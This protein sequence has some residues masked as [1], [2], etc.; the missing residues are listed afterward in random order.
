MLAM[1]YGIYR[2]WT[3]LIPAWVD[4]HF[5]CSSQTP[6]HTFFSSFLEFQSFLSSVHS[7]HVFLFLKKKRRKDDPCSISKQRFNTLNTTQL[8][9]WYYWDGV[10]GHRRRWREDRYT[11]SGETHS[12]QQG[13]QRKRVNLSVLFCCCCHGSEGLL[14]S[15]KSMCMQWIRVHMKE[16]PW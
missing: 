11:I 2:I 6:N 15:V 7:L 13:S 14:D 1:N 16:E 3:R 4:N 5:H 12:H 8:Q 10:C 9:K